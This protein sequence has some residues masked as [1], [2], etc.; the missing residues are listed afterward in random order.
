MPAGRSGR[1]AWMPRAGMGMDAH[2]R[3][4]RSSPPASSPRAGGGQD[5]RSLGS[6]LAGRCGA[7][8]STSSRVA[9]RGLEAG[10]DARKK[11]GEAGCRTP[12]SE[13]A[14]TALA[15]TSSIFWGLSFHFHLWAG[16]QRAG[17]RSESSSVGG[18][19]AARA[20]AVGSGLIPSS[21]GFRFPSLVAFF[22]C[23]FV[24]ILPALPGKILPSPPVRPPPVLSRVD[25]GCLLS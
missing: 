2:S 6:G 14:F 7:Q 25:F 15:L 17:V 9:S 19:I 13:R 16:V 12:L 10:M 1:A 5:A 22:A 4:L 18:C 11:T 24:A 20:P 21:R 23:C 3:P 8:R